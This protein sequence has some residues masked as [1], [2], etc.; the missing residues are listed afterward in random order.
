VL[1]DPDGG[2]LEIE[3]T[4]ERS[5]HTCIMKIAGGF[6]LSF[7]FAFATFLSAEPSQSTLSRQA[8]ITKDEAEH[9]ALARVPHGSIKSA[10]IENEKGH[11]VWSFDISTP[12]TRNLTE[13]LVDAKSG[14]II[15]QQTETP[16]DQA[17]EAAAD[18][19][20]KH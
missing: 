9:L 11:L 13:I 17:K 14:E 20:S 18:R 3:Q 4:H 6:A 16:P 5:G 2:W 10:E 15:S 8:K 19:N 1:P 12:G 7:L